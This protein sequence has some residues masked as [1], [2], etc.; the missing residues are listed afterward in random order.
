MFAMDKVRVPAGGESAHVFKHKLRVGGVLEAR[1][2]VVDAL[3]EDNVAWEILKPPTRL[4]VLLVSNDTDEKSFLVRAVGAN[5]GS[6]DGMVLTPE[7][8]AR[9]IAPNPSV[10]RDQRDAVIFD[11]WVPDNAAHLPPTHLLTID[12]VPPGMPA[13]AGKPFDKPLIRKWETGHPLMS[14]LNLRNVFITSA[15]RVDVSEPQKGQPPVERVAEMVTSPLVLAWEREMPNGRTGGNGTNRRRVRSRPQRFVVI[16]FDP[17]A[18]DIVLRK[19][20][21]LLLWNSFLWFQKGTEPSTQ[22]APGAT[23]TLDAAEVPEAETVTV[24][25]PTGRAERVPIDPESGAAFFSATAS[26]GVYRYT[27][28][29]REDAFAVNTGAPFESDV[30]P[31]EDLALDAEMLDAE[32]LAA[33][34]PAGR[35]LWPYL[36][37]VAALALTFEAIVFHRRVYF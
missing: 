10:L 27:I 34:F 1:L 4:R 15:R 32:A 31:A 20:L 24:A 3:A 13:V 36:L 35:A 12:C 9:A 33:I 30:R 16:A 25:R 37:I 5:A 11:R 21:P 17:R 26:A 18:S 2:R 14:Y 22:V 23:I 28:G 29:S 6:V 7:Q 19:E 8:Y